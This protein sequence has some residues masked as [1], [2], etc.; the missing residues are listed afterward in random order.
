MIADCSY[1]AEFAHSLHQTLCRFFPL[2]F[3]PKSTFPDPNAISSSKIYANR[4]IA[5]FK[6][7]VRTL[8]AGVHQSAIE[9]N[10]QLFNLD[11]QFHF[12]ITV[13]WIYISQIYQPFIS[14]CY[15]IC[16]IL[17]L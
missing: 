6:S 14:V 1:H 10:H 8:D 13:T 15:F 12:L 2:L 11:F 3:I 17:T 7:P 16:Q 4:A 5:G 9:I